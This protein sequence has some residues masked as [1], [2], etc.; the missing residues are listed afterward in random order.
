MPTETGYVHS[1]GYKPQGPFR[2]GSAAGNNPA[3]TQCWINDTTTTS[4]IYESV[5]FFDS[6][7]TTEEKERAAQET[8][9]KAIANNSVDWYRKDRRKSTQRPTSAQNERYKKLRRNARNYPGSREKYNWEAANLI[10]QINNHEC[11]RNWDEIDLHGLFLSEAVSFLTSI[12]QQFR[13]NP[14][15]QD[16]KYL[17]V[18]VGKG[19]HSRKGPVIGPAVRTLLEKHGYEYW[20]GNDL[21]LIIIKL[22]G[23]EEG[24]ILGG[25]ARRTRMVQESTGPTLDGQPHLMNPKAPIWVPPTV[26]LAKSQISP[27]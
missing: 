13:H 21:G 9:Y 1:Q 15:I 4:E 8:I 22:R 6:R 26:S 24:E 3:D 25:F 2:R 12:L 14:A 7:I 18:I 23:Q 17:T 16:H 10:Y 27:R 19:I 11:G 5:A 20:G